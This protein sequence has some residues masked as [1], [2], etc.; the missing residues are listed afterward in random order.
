MGLLV[1]QGL[2]AVFE[3]AQ[4]GVIVSD[5]TDGAGV[6]QAKAL[7]LGQRAVE[8]RRL[9]ADFAAAAEDLEA[10]HEE[11]DF[12][13]AAGSALD[14]VEAV[15]AAGVLAHVGVHLVQRLDR[16]VVDVTAVDE[17][18][19]L[20]HQARPLRP[21][22]RHRARLDQRV[23]FPIPPLP[24]VVLL[25][26]GQVRGQRARVAE[27]PQA[28]VDAETEAVPGDVGEARDHG[29][30]MAGEE[31]V[32]GQRPPP[33][34]AAALG[35]AEHHVDV[36]RQVELAAAELAEADDEGALRLA[37]GPAG[38]AVFFLESPPVFVERGLQAGLREHSEAA[39]GFAERRQAA[40]VAPDDAQHFAVAET[41]QA[42]LE[43]MGPDFLRQQPGVG[44]IG[45][46]DRVGPLREAVEQAGGKIA[47]GAHV[48][49]PLPG[50]DGHGRRGVPGAGRR[51]AGHAWI[52]RCHFVHKV[53]MMV[54]A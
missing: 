51:G 18:P 53:L 48:I 27:R 33:V 32:V 2:N 42:G 15:L 11:L 35:E 49:E 13:N 12:A 52:I 19:E 7:D 14:V 43:A 6:Q 5:F 4:E 50:G 29:P 9:Q 45:A 1:A 24:L 26:R 40:E 22:A 3:Q 47:A 17:G 25:Q 36:G 28:R 37:V 41:A 39:K 34:A 21:V 44:W 31:L 20:L 23:A 46:V 10:L 38:H 16:A 8:R 30:C 54:K